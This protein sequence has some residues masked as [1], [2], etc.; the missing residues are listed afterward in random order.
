MWGGGGDVK[1]KKE[2]M[3]VILTK[4]YW[5]TFFFCNKRLP[6]FVCPVS[7]VVTL[8]GKIAD[9]TTLPHGHVITAWDNAVLFSFY[10]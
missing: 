9:Y 8:K 10:F 2:V 7:R 4:T 1:R 6:Y 3:N 5:K